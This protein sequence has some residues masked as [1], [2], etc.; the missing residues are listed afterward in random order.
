[1]CSALIK[2]VNEK[3]WSFSYTPFLLHH[4]CN[5]AVAI[6]TDTGNIMADKISTILKKIT[7]GFYPVKCLFHFSNKKS[8]KTICPLSKNTNWNIFSA[9]LYC[10]FVI[11]FKVFKFGDANKKKWRIEVLEFLPPSS[12]CQG[13]REFCH[14]LL[15]ISWLLN[16]AHPI[17]LFWCIYLVMLAST[18]QYPRKRRYCIWMMI[19]NKS[20]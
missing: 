17:N 12:P 7:G 3:I 16:Q 1:M 19:L 11:V 2:G 15:Y 6:T 18:L 10:L 14:H 13:K 4:T 5:Q 8:M 9:L 20:V